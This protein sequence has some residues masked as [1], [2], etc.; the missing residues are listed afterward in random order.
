MRALMSSVHCT[1]RD[2]GGALSHTITWLTRLA[3]RLQPCAAKSSNH[4]A[5]L[6]PYKSPHDPLE[7]PPPSTVL[8]ISA[9]TFLWQFLPCRSVLSLGDMVGGAGKVDGHSALHGQG[10]H[11]G[12]LSSRS[13]LQDRFVAEDLSILLPDI[14]TL[15]LEPQRQDRNAHALPNT[16][17]NF[18]KG[19]DQVGGSYPCQ[20]ILH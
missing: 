6:Q 13:T 11:S 3:L 9:A 20:A 5:S 16:L 1:P 8:R 12:A 2:N 15:S 19:L 17:G 7:S 4:G 14:S 10:D 18:S